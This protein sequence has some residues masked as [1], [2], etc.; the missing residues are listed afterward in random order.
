LKDLLWNRNVEKVIAV[1][2]EEGLKTRKHQTAL[3][4]LRGHFVSNKECMRYNEYRKK[5]YSTG[6]GAAESANK[7]IVADRMKRSGMRRSLQHANA[8]MWLRCKY[9]E[10]QWDE[11][12]GKMKLPDYMDHDYITHSVA[13]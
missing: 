1:L 12:W 10:D 7:Y 3:F 6:S 9:Y 8:L 13:A 11:F 4:E 2:S 5:G